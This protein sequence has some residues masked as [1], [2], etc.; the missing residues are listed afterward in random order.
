[1]FSAR[2]RNSGFAVRLVVGRP[3]SAAA[4]EK[5]GRDTYC[6]WRRTGSRIGLAEADISLFGNNQWSVFL[7]VFNEDKLHLYTSEHRMNYC[8][9]LEFVLHVPT[10]SD[11][12]F[13]QLDIYRS[14]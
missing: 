14:G 1:M 13:W 5:A 9:A 10:E 8:A 3:V 6:A 2:V 7:W 4:E 12:S 11:V